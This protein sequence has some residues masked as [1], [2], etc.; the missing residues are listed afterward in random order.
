[1]GRWPDRSFLAVQGTTSTTRL[2]SPILDEVCPLVSAE[3]RLKARTR[4]GPKREHSTFLG[5]YSLGREG[6][7]PVFLLGCP[8]PGLRLVDQ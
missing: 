2:L 3:P 4:T 7:Y 8:G 1:M 5:H 6:S